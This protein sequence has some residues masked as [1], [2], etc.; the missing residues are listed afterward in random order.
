ML[1]QSVAEGLAAAEEQGPFEVLLSDVGLPDGTGM[2][3]LKK[4]GTK[5][6]AHAIAVSGLGMAQDLELSRDAG[7]SQHLT[8]PVTA[9]RLKLLLEQL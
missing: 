8:K 2:D 1:A 4:L 9:E 5:R 7:F 3:L 6:P